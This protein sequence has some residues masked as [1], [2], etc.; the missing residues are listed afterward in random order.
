MAS[1]VTDSRHCLVVPAPGRPVQDLRRRPDHLPHQPI[2]Q[3][4]DFRHRQRDAARCLALYAVRLP[5]LLT[6]P[7]FAPAFAVAWVTVR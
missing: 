1:I 3:A 2:E 5:V 4:P 6:I 7:P